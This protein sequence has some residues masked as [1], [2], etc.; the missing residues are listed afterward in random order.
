MY[1]SSVAVNMIGASCSSLPL[2]THKITFVVGLDPRLLHSFVEHLYVGLAEE[3]IRPV[4]AE[5]DTF[6][7]IID[8]E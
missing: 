1:E 2:L 3:L 5:C 8:P 6:E 7:Q 4:I